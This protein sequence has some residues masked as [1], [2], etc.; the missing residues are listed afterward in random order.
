MAYGEDGYDHKI[1]LRD[2]TSILKLV[3][4]DLVFC[5]LM[6]VRNVHRRGVRHLKRCAVWPE[7]SV[8]GEVEQTVR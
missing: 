5:G 2:I 4:P 3:F 7:K 8:V 1:N 6:S